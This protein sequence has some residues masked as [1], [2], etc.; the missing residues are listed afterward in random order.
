MKNSNYKFIKC[1]KFLPRTVLLSVYILSKN[2]VS[3]KYSVSL[4][5]QCP[6]E[7]IT[8]SLIS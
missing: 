3:A 1:F 6:I 4:A 7:L 8:N 5:F 2:V